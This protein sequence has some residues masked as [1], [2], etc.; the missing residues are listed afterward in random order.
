MGKPSAP[1]APNYTGAAQA[2]AQ[3]NLDQTRAALA[4]SLIGQNTPYGSLSYKQ[5][6]TDQFGNPMWTA[7]QTLSPEQQA[8]YQSGNQAAQQYANLANQGLMNVGDL[9]SHPGIDQSRL[10]Q[11]PVNAGQTAQQAVMSRLAPD[12]AKQN[13]AFESQMA[14]QGISPGTE[15]YRTAK[16][17]QDQKQ[18]DMMLQAGYQG[19][20]ID[21][22]ARQQGISEQLAQQNQI[23]NLLNA[24]R[25]GS[26]V[27]NPNFVN[28]PQQQAAAGPDYLGAASAQGT[29]QQGLY[30]AQMGG[31]SGMNQGLF[32]LGNALISRNWSDRRLKRNIE[33]IGTHKLGI[34]IYKF[35]YIWGEPSIGVMADEVRSVMPDAVM[36]QPNG[37]DMVDY[38][39]LG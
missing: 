29:Y 6:G 27:Q 20:G 7:E 38:G 17:M 12:I 31:A 10:A 30:N 3:G 35:D 11:A 18:N 13:A 14:S 37:F 9:L 23:M 5:T 33:R 36:T 25:T 19:I 16:A 21:Q 39:K 15:A 2:T 34:G 26:Q 24:L 28:T 8:L 1:A 22:A 32:G 4:G